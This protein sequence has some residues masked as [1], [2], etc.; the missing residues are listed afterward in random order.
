M[1]R[2]PTHLAFSDQGDFLS[3]S[4][5]GRESSVR[6]ATL[7]IMMIFARKFFPS[8][9]RKAGN[10]AI[11]SCSSTTFSYLKRLF[12]N[13]ANLIQHRFIFFRAHLLSALTRARNGFSSQMSVWSDKS[14]AARAAYQL[15]ATS[16]LVDSLEIHYGK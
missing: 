13:L 9:D 10:T 1:I 6:N 3:Y 14:F 4:L 5:S 7:P 11:I 15:S 12:A 16:S 8:I 2:C